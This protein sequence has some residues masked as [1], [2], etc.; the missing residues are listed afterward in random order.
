MNHVTI[1]SDCYSDATIVSNQ[2]ID[3]YMKDANDAQIKVYMYLL[4][5]NG[6]NMNISISSMADFFNYTEK[7]V[8]RALKYW[9]KQKLIALMF[10]SGKHL[11]GIKLLPIIKKEDR[12]FD[13]YFEED[14][15]ITLEDK[16]DTVNYREEAVDQMKLNNI[17][18]GNTKVFPLPAKPN[19]SAKRLMEFKEQPDVSQLL[20]IAEQYL[21]RTLS[22]NDINSFLYMYDSLGF[23]SDLI[24]YLIEYCVTNKK[25]NIYYIENVANNWAANGVKDV[26]EAK[27]HTLN[28]PREVF[29]VFKA[30]GINCNRKPIDPEV[31]YVRCWMGE[32]GMSMDIIAEACQRT[33]MK[34][35]SPSFEYANTIL[36]NWSQ[37][38]V[39]TVSDIAALDDAFA[40]GKKGLSRQNTA[41]KKE[42]EKK[43]ADKNIG[44]ASDKIAKPSANK[45]NN[46]SQRSYDYSELEKEILSN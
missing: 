15:N 5:C 11:S 9:E 46:F 12:S 33:I 28:V 43:S 27:V 7:D 41:E 38:G 17:E 26:E 36:V 30:F 8:V 32:L 1:I 40:K 10:D 39:K 25:K 45:F 20:F 37:A 24:E 16:K 35:H 23:N 29:E 44:L 13:E 14:M 31:N 19:F 2:F 21:G 22:S 42:T 34:I 18:L 3:G 4:R 6:A